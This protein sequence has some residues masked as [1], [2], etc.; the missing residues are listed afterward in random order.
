M[1]IPAI[2]DTN[3]AGLKVIFMAVSLFR[4]DDR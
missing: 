3:G 4:E 1:R 2:S